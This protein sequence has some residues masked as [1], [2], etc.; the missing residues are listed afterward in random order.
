MV[1]W[2]QYSNMIGRKK[3]ASF[4]SSWCEQFWNHT[5]TIAG[6][7]IDSKNYQNPKWI[8]IISL[9]SHSFEYSWQTPKHF[10]GQVGGGGGGGG[11]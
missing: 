7:L 1:G 5:D 9:K 10:S 3:D 8:I 11:F 4:N 6:N 2:D